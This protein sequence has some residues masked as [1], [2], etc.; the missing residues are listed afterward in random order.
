MTI[1]FPKWFGTIVDRIAVHDL[2]VRRYFPAF[3]EA[4]RAV[5]LIRSF[6]R[7]REVSDHGQ[8][9]L[10]FAD[11]AITAL[12]FDKAFVESLHLGKG[13]GEATRRLVEEISSKKQRPVGARDLVHTLKISKDQAYG[14]LRY[15]AQMGVI[16]RANQPEKGNRKLFS[17]TPRPRFVPDPEKLFHELDDIKGEVRFVHPLTGKWIVYRRKH[18]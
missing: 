9:E 12:I 5:C 2:R 17:P 4:C 3:I 7:H 10:E 13:A 14:K 15:A 18:D 6:Q 16:V 1:T 11:F 8:L